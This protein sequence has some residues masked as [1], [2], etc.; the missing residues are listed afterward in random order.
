M[1]SVQV[2]YSEAGVVGQVLS[3]EVRGYGV[4]VEHIQLLMGIG[5]SDWARRCIEEDMWLSAE[6]T[7]QHS[8]FVCMFV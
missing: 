2:L 8:M 6:C 7:L 5:M 4:R 3:R 1:C